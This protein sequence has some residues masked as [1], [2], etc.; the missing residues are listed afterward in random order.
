MNDIDQA[1]DFAEDYERDVP[2]CAAMVRHYRAFGSLTARQ[3][4][5]LLR[6]R[7]ERLGR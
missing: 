1:I 2:F 7:R 3:V 6:I 5:V 4:E